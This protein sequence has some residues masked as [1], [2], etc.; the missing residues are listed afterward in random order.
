MKTKRG[1]TMAFVTLDD[2]SGRLEVAIFSDT[3]NEYREKLVKDSL[4]V[5]LSIP[6][7]LVIGMTV[8]Y[9]AGE[10]LNILTMIGLMICVGLLVDNSVVVAEN[11]HRLHREGVSRRDACIRGADEVALAI[12]MSTCPPSLC[13]QRRPTRPRFAFAQRAMT[14][15]QRSLWRTF[16]A[17]WS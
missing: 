14:K 5:V 17:P 6:L 2:R 1:D 11:I 10:T 3:Y 12:T 8:M 9:F 13:C 16:E 15:K 4:L 7:S